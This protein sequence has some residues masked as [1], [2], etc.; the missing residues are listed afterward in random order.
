MH[1]TVAE[2]MNGLRQTSSPDKLICR[3]NSL[4]QGGGSR[5][6]PI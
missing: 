1:F 4:N 2:Q 5:T 6:S 3:T